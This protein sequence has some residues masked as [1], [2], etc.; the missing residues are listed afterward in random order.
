MHTVGY[1][2][3]TIDNDSLR[4]CRNSRSST[5]SRHCTPTPT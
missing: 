2:N 5:P 4:N 1:F 3:I